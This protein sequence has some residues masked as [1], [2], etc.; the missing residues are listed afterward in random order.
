MPAYN[1]TK[2]IKNGLIAL[3]SGRINQNLPEVD[4]QCSGQFI[5]RADR[6][7]EVAAFYRSNNSF[8]YTGKNSKC[9][10]RIALGS[11]D[12]VVVFTGQA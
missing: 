7:I 2:I 12:C 1:G 4:V 5:N 8:I 6:E 9:L 3:I 10:N 11:S